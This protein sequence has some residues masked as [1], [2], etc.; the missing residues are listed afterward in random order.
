MSSSCQ[1][2]GLLTA[3]GAVLVAPGMQPPCTGEAGVDVQAGVVKR[4]YAAGQ[5]LEEAG[6]QAA[7]SAC[8]RALQK[9]NHSFWSW[10]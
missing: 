4:M 5:Q 7:Y 9:E 8:H 6:L 10:P 1:A 2:G 3:P